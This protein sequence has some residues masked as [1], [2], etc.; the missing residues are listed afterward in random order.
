MGCFKIPFFFCKVGGIENF[1]SLGGHQGRCSPENRSGADRDADVSGVHR[2]IRIPR[3]TRENS[4]PGWNF[5][6]RW[7][8]YS[9]SSRDGGMLWRQEV[10]QDDCLFGGQFGVEAISVGE[11]RVFRR[12]R[13]RASIAN[14]RNLRLFL[15]A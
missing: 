6:L 12:M 15:T 11:F 2:G 8:E 10:E 9:W 13:D 1:I 5:D 7:M 14:L 3:G 4:T